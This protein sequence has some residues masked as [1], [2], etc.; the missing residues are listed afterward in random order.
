MQNVE[1]VGILE[2]GVQSY[3]FNI[4]EKMHISSVVLNDIVDL[5]LEF[6]ILQF[7][8]GGFNWLVIE[9]NCVELIVTELRHYFYLQLY[10]TLAHNC[11][12]QD[13]HFA[14]AAGG[15]HG[16]QSEVLGYGD[17]VTGHVLLQDC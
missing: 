6:L 5:L 9:A 8:S 3:Y 4:E 13:S 2:I 7:G 10:A 15:E 16:V 12:L 11:F 17:G 1:L 14:V